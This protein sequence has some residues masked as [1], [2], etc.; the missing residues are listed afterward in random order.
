MLSVREALN[1]PI[2][3]T[4]QLVAG[5]AGLDNL[6]EWV[7]IVDIP[8]AQF[9]YDRQGILLLTTGIGMQDDEAAQAGLI[10]KL[11]NQGFSGLVW[12]LGSG[13][14]AV[15]D[16]V[17]NEAEKQNFPVIT[18]P[19]DVMFVD[20]SKQILDRITKRQVRLLKRSN[21]IQGQ[22]TDI[23]LKGGTLQELAE[24][25]GNSIQR[26]ISI[27]DSSFRVVASHQVGPIDDSRKRTLAN[28]RTPPD[29][30]QGLIDSGI[31]SRLLQKMGPIYLES[32]PEIGLDFERVVAPIIVDREIYG[33]MWIISGDRP[34]TE[35][36]E[37]ATEQA[38]TVAALL[39]FKNMAVQEATESLRGDFL[40]ELLNGNIH[41][42]HFSE[43]A[44]RLGFK[45]D[46]SHQILLIQ[47][48]PKAGGNGRSLYDN[49][50]QWLHN[51]KARP[52]LISRDKRIVLILESSDETSGKQ[53]AEGLINDLNHPAC[54]LLIGIGQPTKLSNESEG[55]RESY[56]QAEE[57][58]QIGLALNKKNEYLLFSDLG[59]HHWLYHLPSSQ[60]DGN[61]FLGKI[62]E[63]ARYDEARNTEL[64]KTLE[65]YLDHGGSLVDTAESLYIHR[66]TLLHRL[67]RIKTLNHIDLRNPIYRL[68]LHIAVKAFRL[69]GG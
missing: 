58:L 65:A 56:E 30:A 40:E 24:M 59:L 16:L 31:Y 34:F 38:A 33:Y 22:L 11:T 9:E 23:V 42:I 68:N 2:M 55:L 49:V 69:N 52:L 44:H 51:I 14:T 4:C 54:P 35:L 19:K 53:I 20:L 36:D 13:F 50:Q 6:I 21:N 26:S 41:S 32:M 60:Q 28:G 1:L 46:K 48:M 25:L 61:K 39:L 64:V 37:L 66:N 8:N 63:L 5:E 27:E 10:Q 29:M 47:G 18:S 12:S 17:K 62:R 57:A 15:P 43:Q 67:E 3:S 7:H 45:K